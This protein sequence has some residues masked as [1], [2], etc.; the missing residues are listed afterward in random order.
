MKKRKLIL[1]VIALMTL[2]VCASAQTETVE[3]G[4][5][6]ELV[7]KSFKEKNKERLYDISADYPELQNFNPAI[8]G[9]FNQLIK[10]RVMKDVDEF[11]KSMLEM[12]EEDLKFAREREVEN[13]SETGYWV[14]TANPN[15]I[16]IGFG[17][18]NYSGGAHPN[19]YSYSFNFDLKNGKELK[20]SD[21]FLPGSNYLKVISDYAIADLTKQLETETD[22]E[23]LARGAGPKAENFESWTIGE[24][25]LKIQFDAYQVAAYVY[26]PQEVVI[27]FDKLKSV[28]R[29]FDFDPLRFAANGNPVNWCRNGLF[30]K[31]GENFRL[32]KV[33][34]GSGA[35]AFFYGDDGKDCPGNARCKTRSYV[36]PGDEVIVSGTYSGYACSWYQPKKGNETVGWISLDD[37][38]MTE[39][40]SKPALGDWVGNWSFAE[41]SIEIRSSE[42]SG[43]LKITGNAFWKGA[44]DN[45]HIGELDDEAAPTGDKLNFGGEDEYDC[46]VRMQR[47]GRFLIVSDNLQCG[48]VNVTFSGVYQKK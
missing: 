11:R 15:L 44:G 5:G 20:L 28:L 3:F 43:F 12:S 37:L 2:A 40:A 1:T 6:A 33:V 42:K 14:A 27:P 8:A 46:R 19:S 4:D 26:G 25:G 47:L 36:I 17:N 48:G 21:L 22:D 13:Y 30:P 39:T 34:G 32:A 38:S 10:A 24:D 29:V 16:S 35:K 45:I 41:N 18:G 23:W 7:L 9:R 31:D